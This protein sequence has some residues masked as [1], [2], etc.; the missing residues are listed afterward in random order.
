MTTEEYRNHTALNFSSAKHLLKS[1]AEYMCKISEQQTEPTRQMI[2]GTCLHAMVLEG[3][4]I[5]D[6]CHTKP[7]GL[8]LA[9]SEG[10]AWKE[11]H[12]SL[13]ILS[14]DDGFGLCVMRRYV[15][16]NE[17]ANSILRHCNNRET[18]IIGKFHGVE[19][20]GMI[21][22]YSVHLGRS[23]IVMC[24]I[25][26]TDDP[27]PHA[28]AKTVMDRDYDMQAAWY[29]ELVSQTV[30]TDIDDA[31]FYWIA[32]QN[33]APFSCVVYDASEFFEIGL[34]KME[35]AISKFKECR[36]SNKWPHPHQGINTLKAPQWYVEKH[37]Y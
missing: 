29:L 25:K 23:E 18:P 9:T 11:R 20:K 36:E 30:S 2:I 21:D 19:I 22:A 37:L 26:T 8:S 3:K 16:E 17:S 1:P 31:F 13:P 28:F 10:K 6:V 5:D 14:F 7:S 33:K 34:R 24:D 35:L 4:N 15:L 27:S 32:V 12:S